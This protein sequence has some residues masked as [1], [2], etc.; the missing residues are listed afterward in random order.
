MDGKI[1]PEEIYQKREELGIQN[2]MNLLIEIIDSEK[3]IESRKEGIKYLGLTC[4]NS[5]V[6][7]Q[8]CF[9]V[10]ENILISEENLKIKCE[11][12]IALGKTRFE[13]AL[14]PLKWILENEEE[15]EKYDLIL[16]SLRGITDIRFGDHEISLFIRF[17]NH[18]YKPI[19]EYVVNELI[20]LSP[21]ELI[22][23]LLKSLNNQEL[24]ESQKIEIVNLIGFE[25]S[26]INVTFEDA[27]FLK[28]KYPEVISNLN[29]NKNLLLETIVPNLKATEKDIMKHSLTILR[30]IE[31]DIQEDLID[32]LS[33]D[34]F[35]IRRNAIRLIG[36][37]EIKEAVEPLL[38]HL[39]DMYDE[40]TLATIEALGNI[41]DLSAVPELLK[42]LDIEEINYEY[43]DLDFK[44]FILDAIKNIYL[45]NENSS[46]DVLFSILERDN[47]ILKESIAYL[48]GEIGKESF[49]QPLLPLLDEKNFDV[50]KN[51]IIALGKIGH[52]NA[53]DPLISVLND[54]L[55][56]WLIK[57]VAMDAIFNIFLKNLYINESNRR[58]TQ[59]E[60]IIWTEKIIYALKREEDENFKVKLAIIKFLEVFGGNTALNA[61]LRQLD[62]FYRVVGIAATR[63]IKKIEKRIE[64]EQE[65]N[66]AN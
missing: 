39:D 58:Y 52:K 32:F 13:D 3:E 62:N 54:N 26:S 47:D 30:N 7:K 12:A 29:K 35:I 43:I 9:E 59:R 51:A 17:L 63:A 23:N 27:S 45:K 2:S 20:G 25:L 37:L 31:K 4:Y 15:A 49:L 28:V 53:L 6:M 14:K 38:Q 24:S 22:N 44:F 65:N 34:D 57:K 48:L 10:L 36:E 16:S 18:D 19:K 66:P 60:F 64:L 33:Y 55:S 8:E 1:L 42:V 40:V 11:A 61:L 50:K 21:E 46:Y 56:Y 5:T 41:G